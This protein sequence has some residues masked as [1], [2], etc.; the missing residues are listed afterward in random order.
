MLIGL[1]NQH[2]SIALKCREGKPN[3]PV[4]IKTRLGWTVCGAGTAES[5]TSPVHSVYH[6]GSSENYRQSDDDLHQTIKEYFALDSMGI[7]KPQE[8][9]H[10]TTLRNRFTLAPRLNPSAGQPSDGYTTFYCLEKRM[11]KDEALANILREKISEHLNKGYIRKLSE[12]ELR[13]SF[14]RI[15]YLPMFPVT[16]PNKPDKVRIVWDAAAEAFGTSLNSALLKGPENSSSLFAVLTRF[17]EHPIALTGDIREMF[18]Q[19]LIRNEDQQCQRFYWRDDNGQIATYAMCVMTFGACCSPSCAQYVMR[20]NAARFAQDYPAAVEV[21]ENR[22]YVDDMLVSVDT[23]EEAIKLARDVKFVHSQG[24]FEIRNWTSN[25]RRVLECMHGSTDEEKSLD[26]SPQMTTE[27]YLECGGVPLQTSS[28][29]RSNGIVTIQTCGKLAPKYYEVQLH[30]FVDSSE[31]GMAAACYL[32]FVQDE[33]VH[34][35]LVAAK[36]RVA[37][38]K[39]HSIPRL[40][41]MAAVIGTRL[42]RTVLDSLSF[43]VSKLFYH[44]DSQDVICWLYSD[45]RRYTPFV[46]CRVSEILEA[47]ELDQW[48]WVPT[49]L[50]VADE[51]TKWGKLPDMTTDSRWFNGPQFLQQPE[52]EWPSQL[53]RN[54]QTD[55]ELRPRLLTHHAISSPAIHVSSWKRLITI[56]AFVHRFIANCRRKIQK[57]SIICDTLSTEELQIA[58]RSVI[59]QVQREVYPSEIAA[60]KD[61]MNGPTNCIP[62][63]SPLFKLTPWLDDQGLLRMRGRISACSLATEDAKNPIILPR[64]HHTT[65]LI[66]S[67]YHN[68]Y[69]HINHETTINELRQRYCIP[70]LR[71]TYAKIRYNCQYCKNHRAVPRPPIMAD[72][73]SERLDA[74]ARPFTHIGI[75]YFGPIEVA[76]GRRVEKRWGMLITCLTIR[77]IHIEVVHTLSTDSCIMG[78][79]NFVARRGTPKTIYSDHGT[80]FI[81]ASRELLEAATTINQDEIMKEFSS[82]EISW[83]FIPPASP[84]MGGSWERLIGTVKRN[85]M[86]IRPC[87]S[88]MT[89]S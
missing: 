29:S 69:H 33:A 37:P 71:A 12:D 40:E 51:G 47:T 49:K 30:T 54:S 72:L 83:K 55:T 87:I 61:S 81:G 22:H 35:C 62:K 7:M 77:A 31:N 2:L 78:L 75:D 85:L 19:V 23:E 79:R 36:T 88:P 24:G 46:A 58:E 10:R 64:D 76:L 16:N 57:K 86:E 73:P 28:P 45:H 70:R 32:R 59:R 63:A 4:A 26:L 52:K 68:K 20:L 11:K 17:R 65:S 3:D 1:K 34:C 53:A 13:Q 44:S 6:I 8:I 80:C 25:S 60:L 50:N 27:K 66:I 82:T 41:L 18:H 43:N 38:L 48:R 67:H 5:A 56:S 39:Y 89:R 42:S 84:H 9:T 14:H 21:I 15:W 74:F